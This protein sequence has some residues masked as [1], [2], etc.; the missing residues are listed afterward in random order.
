MKAVD[1][2]VMA[3]GKGT[4]M[5]SRTPKVLH[6]LGGRPLIAHVIE[7]AQAL[8]ARRTIVITG[9]GAEGVEAWLRESAAAA[10]RAAP[11]FV[12]QEPQ[13]IRKDVSAERAILSL[14]GP[15]AREALDVAPPEEEHA[16]VH[17][18]HGIYVSTDLGVDVICA[19]ADADAVR[20]ALGI[21]PASEEAAECLRIESGRPPFATRTSLST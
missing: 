18:E 15:A 2:V 6:K 13:L 14:I 12:R 5:K 19:A 4:R 21:E 9:H 20:E 10:G 17:G 11:D 16:F 7:T 8:N 1:V 3:A